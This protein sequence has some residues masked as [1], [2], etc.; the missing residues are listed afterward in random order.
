MDKTDNIKINLKLLLGNLVMLIGIIVFVLLFSK[1]FG[2][3][4]TLVGVAVITAMLMFKSINISLRYREAIWAIIFSFIYMGFASYISR[5][6]AFIGIPINF[7]LVFIVIYLFTNEMETKAYLPF[8]L[9]YVFLDGD[10]ISSEQLMSRIIGLLTGGI[11]IAFIYY[12]SHKNLDDKN[13]LT[14]WEMISN[15][16]TNSLQFNFSLRMAIGIS[17]A[18]FIGRTFGFSKSMWI[19][20]TVMSLTQPHYYQT[21]E[22]IKQR[23]IG[24]MVG[25]IIFIIL[26]ECLVPSKFSSLVLL[27]LSY[28]YTFIKKYNK[29]IIFVTLNSLGAAMVLF[30]TFISVPMR[31]AF[32]LLGSVIAFMVNKTIY[33]RMET[34]S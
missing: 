13:H 32:V 12:I 4:N 14:I 10:P 15:I 22:R 25:S 9:C 6:N 21:K 2:S 1:F 16:K 33:A 26:F 34:Y 5:L 23:V 31:I 7:I 19:S 8:I 24:T 18:M 30:D 11:L 17:I 28:I 27:I 20:I 29:Q 3:E